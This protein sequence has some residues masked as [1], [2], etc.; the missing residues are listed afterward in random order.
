M[1]R[2]HNRFQRFDR[3][4]FTCTCCGRRTRDTGQGNLELCEQCWALAGLQNVIFDGGTIEEVAND[5]DVYFNH[6]V[7]LG[8]DPERLKKEFPR[9][10]KAE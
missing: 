2:N 6:A 9:L 10:W 4:T 5:R 7:K 3:P 1:K 8:S